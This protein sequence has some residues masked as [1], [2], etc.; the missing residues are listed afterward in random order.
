MINS[1]SHN[2]QIDIDPQVNLDRDVFS[3]QTLATSFRELIPLPDVSRVLGIVSAGQ[4]SDEFLQASIPLILHQ[5]EQNRR[6]ADIVI[7][8]NHGATCPLL[9]EDLTAHTHAK[10]IHLQTGEKES[11]SIPAPVYEENRPFNITNTDDELHRI[12][13][14]EQKAGMHT[15]GKIRMLQDAY[16][17]CTSI[18]NAGWRFPSETV[19]FDAESQFLS[20]KS[21]GEQEYEQ[22]GLTSILSKLASNPQLQILGARN[23][24]CMYET[25]PHVGRMPKLSEAISPMH[26]FLNALHGSEGF[27][28]MSGGGT[29]GRTAD[30]L[31]L[32]IVTARY[33]G[34][35]A[36]DTAQSV[37]AE[38]SG[39]KWGIE[40]T[41]IASN[42]CNESS[43]MNA[44][45]RNTA[46][47]QQLTRWMQGTTAVRKL[48]G[49]DTISKIIDCKQLAEL[50]FGDETAYARI[51]NIIG[52]MR[53][54]LLDTSLPILRRI[55]KK[56]AK[57]PDILTG[58]DAIASW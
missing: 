27:R 9:L 42:K 56:A 15:A 44:E 10:V 51:V 55:I 45:Q 25:I 53:I 47:E 49:T 8:M 37:L 20:E 54:Q 35:R 41:V 21:D 50:C 23:R 19:F 17:L 58:T 38:H 57:N 39:M 11:A 18:A 48:Y 31:A 28:W 7:G 29:I 46:A 14:V 26:E 13:V 43:S 6:K 2:V 52:P 40:P 16:S 1:S 33:P 30:M 12:F 34:M 22:T 32:G 24:V 4:D 3:V 5:I 36:E